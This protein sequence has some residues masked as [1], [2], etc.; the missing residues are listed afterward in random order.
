MKIIAT[1]VALPNK[2]VSNYELAEATSNLV[3]PD[4]VRDNLGIINRRVADED[5][6]SS[7]L[8]GQAVNNL[9]EKENI[10]PDSIDMLIVATATP[11][12]LMPS[13]AC[14]V[15]LKTNLK[16]AFCFDIA[17]VCSGFLFGLTTANNYLKSGM[18]KRAIID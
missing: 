16:N 7:D 13:C 11:D 10:D 4:W 8:A 15:Q 3:N 18:V 14:A 5:V 12:I 1:N 9:F 17:A 2:I 6:F